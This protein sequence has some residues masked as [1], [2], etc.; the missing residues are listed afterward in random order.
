M[1]WRMSDDECRRVV[2]DALDELPA[3]LA[4]RLRGVAILVE[5]RH[6]EGLMGIYDPSGGIQRIVVFRD[7]HPTPAEL[8]RTVLHEVGHF[9]GLDEQRLE[10]LGYG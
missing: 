3:D 1:S 6:P 7:A 2:R 8:R 4:G 10:E 5:D 9:F